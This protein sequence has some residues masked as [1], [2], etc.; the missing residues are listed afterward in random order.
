MFAVYKKLLY[1]VPK[2]RPLAYIAIGLT[3]VSTLP[4]V[5]LITT[6]MSF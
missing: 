6:S 1:Y 3:V 2:Q 4:N 5:A